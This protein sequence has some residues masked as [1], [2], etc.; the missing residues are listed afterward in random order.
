MAIA[1]QSSEPRLVKPKPR[2][3]I[4]NNIQLDNTYNLDFIVGSFSFCGWIV[5]D[6]ANKCEDLN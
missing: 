2:E 4:P 3:S 6:T 1:R 5:K